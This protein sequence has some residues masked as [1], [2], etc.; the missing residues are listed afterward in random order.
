MSSP[1]NEVPFDISR[2]SSRT[3]RPGSTRLSR[4]NSLDARAHL[5]G[6]LSNKVAGSVKNYE[7]IHASAKVLT[8]PLQART[9]EKITDFTNA[10]RALPFMHRQDPV[11]QRNICH[12][13]EIKIL[14][15]GE[16]M[17]LGDL[18][19]LKEEAHGYA[20]VKHLQN[21]YLALL[22]GS[23]V[24]KTGGGKRKKILFDDEKMAE[25]A[26]VYKAVDPDGTDAV[27][28]MKI[29][30]FLK[31]EGI[32]VPNEELPM[33]IQSMDPTNKGRLK[34]YDW[35]RLLRR[36]DGVAY[37]ANELLTRRMYFMVFQ[38]IDT[39]G[40]GEI[41][42]EELETAVKSLG[43]DLSSEKLHEMF[44]NACPEDA[45]GIGLTEFI[46]V[47]KLSNDDT[48]RE[49]AAGEALGLRCL[50]FQEEMESGMFEAQRTCEILVLHRATYQSSIYLSCDGQLFEKQETLKESPHFG[51]LSDENSH[52]LGMSS[53]L[54]KRPRGTRICSQGEMLTNMFLV[55]SGE[56]SFVHELVRLS[57][58]SNQFRHLKPREHPA[59]EPAP[60]PPAASQSFNPH[61]KRFVRQKKRVVEVARLG[62]GEL[63]GEIAAMEQVP[64][65]DAIVAAT[66][67][68]LIVLHRDDV[69]RVMSSV[70]LQQLLMQAMVRVET[71]RKQRTSAVEA[72]TLGLMGPIVKRHPSDHVRGTTPNMQMPRLIETL[73]KPIPVQKKPSRPAVHNETN[74]ATTM[75][76]ATARGAVYNHPG[77]LSEAANAIAYFAPPAAG[78]LSHQVQDLWSDTMAA[79]E[80]ISYGMVSQEPAPNGK[81]LR[82][83][84]GM[85][86]QERLRSGRS[87][88]PNFRTGGT[89]VTGTVKQNACFMPNYQR[90]FNVPGMDRQYAQCIGGIIE[91]S[92]EPE[93]SFTGRV[94]AT[95][96][97]LGLPSKMAASPGEV[98]KSQSGRTRPKPCSDGRD[99]IKMTSSLIDLHITP[100]NVKTQ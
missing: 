85:A 71:R 100:A 95:L 2:P 57:L 53:L 27:E 42:E 16:V 26:D 25:L 81:R 74:M 46:S 69:K 84:S 90:R 92:L 97:S 62:Q 10:C 37:W 21:G 91:S 93:R 35:E 75:K 72:T 77:T 31:S 50:M 49:L 8:L 29:L 6:S 54:V 45:D 76:S 79:Q 39:D 40:S 13:M 32:S 36:G 1:T 3:S 4:R 96:P 61:H 20:P 64:C 15:K 48:R 78:K 47:M 17:H 12:V 82:P 18:T 14:Q 88:K 86:G 34:L 58:T 73:E 56:C 65:D 23:A 41:D 11:F 19:P 66:D 22:S 67:V 55:M 94:H 59:M 52:Y 68:E 43:M 51:M 5:L 30:D 44:V 80:P 60:P 89:P 63:I 98:T 28:P 7:E 38:E 24:L 87:K 9:R 83:L 70:E 99:D 33:L